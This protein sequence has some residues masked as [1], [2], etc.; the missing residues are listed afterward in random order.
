VKVRDLMTHNVRICRPE[1]QLDTAAQIMWDNDCGCVPVVGENLKVV[2]MITDRDIC[3]AAYFQDKELRGLTVSSAMSR[4]PVSCG[5][6]DD[7][8]VAEKL[9]QD[10]QVHRLPVT[11]RGGAV[12]G[13]LSIDDIAL[14]AGR[15]LAAGLTPELTEREIVRTLAAVCQP[16]RRG[17]GIPT[18]A[19]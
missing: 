2:G 15:K 8:A 12:I 10:N 9:L 13:V 3:M 17:V 7:I 19:S 6:D 5:A 14:E 4:K 18:Y 16:R 11:D 1:D